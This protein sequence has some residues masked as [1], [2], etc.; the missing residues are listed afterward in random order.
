MLENLLLF[1][2][3]LEGVYTTVVTLLYIC[4]LLLCNGDIEPNPGT[5][6]LKS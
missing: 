5:K 3:Y 1:Y 6:K 4:V 2:H